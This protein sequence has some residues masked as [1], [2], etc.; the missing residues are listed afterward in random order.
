[1]NLEVLRE[2]LPVLNGE[3]QEITRLAETEN[4]DLTTE[5]SAKLDGIL[6]AS[7]RTAADIARLEKLGRQTDSLIQGTGRKTA[8]DQPQNLGDDGQGN[9][10]GPSRDNLPRVPAQYIHH[11]PNWNFRSLGDFALDVRKASMKGGQLTPRLQLSEKLA[12]ATTFGSEGVGADGG[13]AVPPEFRTAIMVALMGEDSLLSRC[14]Q[15]TC[16][17]NTFNAPIDETTPWQTSGGILAFWDGEAQAAT[18]SK[19][20]IQ[21]RTVKLNRLRALVPLT[22]EVLEDA[23]AMDSYLKRK[24]P[25]KLNFKVN[26]AIVSGTGVGTPL[27]ILNSPSRVTVSKESGQVTGTL[28]AMNVMK[29]YNRMYGPSRGKAVWLYNQEIEPQ[30]WKL[31]IPGTD[32]TGNFV[33]AWGIAM[34][35]PPGSLSG[36]MYATLFGRPLIPTQACSSLSTEGDLIFADL[37]QYMALT[38]SSG[39]AIRTDTS[40]HLWFDQDLI[41]YK[42]TIRLGGQPWPSAPYSPLS[43][44]NTYSPFVTLQSR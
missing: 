19:P 34:Y 35:Q 29:M 26:L 21:E 1:M 32:N 27:G 2:R 39:G 12:A 41:A 25:D 30:L 17:G 40:I 20:Q 13:F 31:S 44:S 4:R 16:A 9:V 22:E 23:P 11:P 33:T 14:D 37:S 24:L 38:K 10:T 3:A 5:E 8:P 42:A 6:A 28:I 36:S 18:Q 15:I 43:G 7:D